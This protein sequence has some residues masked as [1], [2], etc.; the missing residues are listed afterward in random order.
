MIS[1]KEKQMLKDFGFK[2]PAHLKK[3][4][5]INPRNRYNIYTFKWRL[6]MMSKYKT[7]S[8]RVKN[9]IVKFLTEYEDYVIKNQKGSL[10]NWP[11]DAKDHAE[12]LFDRLV[13]PWKLIKHGSLLFSVK[14]PDNN[15]WFRALDLEELFKAMK[16]CYSKSKKSGA[17]VKPW[18]L[19][20]K[21]TECVST[22]KRKRNRGF[23]WVGKDYDIALMICDNII[24]TW[25]T[26]TGDWKPWKNSWSQLAHRKLV[27]IKYG[28]IITSKNRG[29]LISPIRKG[30]SQ[31]SGTL[32][33]NMKFDDVSN[34]VFK[35]GLSGMKKAAFIIA[36]AFAVGGSRAAKIING[37]H[38]QHGIKKWWEKR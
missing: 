7:L 17:K 38:E 33:R 16:I 20:L 27:G 22:Y 2:D 1:A 6:K 24:S 26:K 5:K 35:E 18:V 13:K 14:D 29:R 12:Y 30:L 10:R 25:N 4:L 21:W 37:F 3:A 15:Y 11:K 19:S 8:S 28:Y 23:Y 34:L 36:T 31:Y 9:D 32:K